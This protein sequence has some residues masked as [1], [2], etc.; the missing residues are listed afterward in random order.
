MGKTDVFSIVVD[1]GQVERLHTLPGSP[2]FGPLSSRDDE[3][4]YM[5]RGDYVRE[6]ELLRWEI[7]TQRETVLERIPPGAWGWVSPDERWVVEVDRHRYLK[8]RPTAGGDWKPL[9]SDSHAGHFNLT[10]D[11]NWLIYHTVDSAGKHGLY[12]VATAGGQPERLGDFP[13]NTPDGSL[14]ISPDG[15][16]VMVA[17]GEYDTVYELW[18]LENFVPPAP[19]P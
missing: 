17:A 9:L 14:E 3:A 13:T 15:R 10:P 2:L 1:S 5:F 19:K 6:G 16:K 8:I 11:G 18:S 7:A 4:L 12:R